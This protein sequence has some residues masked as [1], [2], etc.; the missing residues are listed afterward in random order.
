MFCLVS[1]QKA[2]AAGKKGKDSAKRKQ[3]AGKGGKGGNAAKQEKDNM[4]LS[5]EGPAP[6]Q[7]PEPGEIVKGLVALHF[8]FYFLVFKL[9]ACIVIV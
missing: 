6:V 4:N 2:A 9:Q 1:L 7:V 8:Y 3:S 5:V